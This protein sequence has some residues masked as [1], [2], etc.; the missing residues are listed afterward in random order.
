MTKFSHSTLNCKGLGAY[1]KEG[2]DVAKLPQL[3]PWPREKRV[4]GRGKRDEGRGTRDEG[5]GTREE[6][7]GKRVCSRGRA[8]RCVVIVAS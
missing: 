1:S 4:D 3:W 7:R 8:P 6:G 2:V 5:R